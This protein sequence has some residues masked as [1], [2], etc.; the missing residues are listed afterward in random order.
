[1]VGERTEIDE[2]LGEQD[3]GEREEEQR[4]GSGPDRDVFVGFLGGLRPARIDDDE[5]TT[6]RPECTQAGGKVGRGEQTAVGRERVRAEHEEIVGAVDV[7]D[8]D[9]QRAAEH[10]AGRDLLRHLVDG[11]RAVDVA[12][13]QR[14]QHAR[15]CRGP[16]RGC[17]R[18][19]CRGTPRPRRSRARRG[20]RRDAARSPRTLR[21]QLTSRHVSPSRIIGTRTRSGSVSS[22]LIAVPFGQRYPRLNTSS[23]SP[24]TRAISRPSMCSSSPHVASHR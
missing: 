15:G 9:R 19:D 21:L 2:I 11:A 12:A 23:R 6:A 1:M 18:S 7:R 4:V 3:V 10:Q 14:L 17:A 22:C 8:R 5:T 16:D 20:S 24:R 13:P